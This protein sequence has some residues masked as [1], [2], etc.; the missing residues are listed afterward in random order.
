MLKYLESGID[1]CA[2]DE[3]K[4]T[5]LHFSAAQGNVLVGKYQLILTI[6]AK[7]VFKIFTQKDIMCFVYTIMTNNYVYNNFLLI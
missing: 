4:R 7:T 5:A 6:S 3:K 1:A 2:A